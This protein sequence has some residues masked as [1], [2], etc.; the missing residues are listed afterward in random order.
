MAGHSGA[1]RTLF[2]IEARFW[3]PTM[4]SSVIS[5]TRNYAHCRLAN[6]SKHESSG[7]L[8]GMEDAAPMDVVFLDMWSPGDSV[9][10]MNSAKKVLTYTYGMSSFAAVAFAGGQI[11]AEYV[12]VLAMESFFLP[13]GLPKLI[14]VDDD[15]IFKGF[16][17]Q[18]FKSLGVPVI[19]VAKENRRAVRN[20]IFHKYLNKV[21]QLHAVDWRCVP[22]VHG[23]FRAEPPLLK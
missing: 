5:L 19:A 23:K 9:V 1:N 20:E 10:D 17:F 14:V 13:F 8:E 11:N 2:R 6:A 12:V 4:S 22:A 21:Q 16:F 15:T 7:L 3:W 18:L